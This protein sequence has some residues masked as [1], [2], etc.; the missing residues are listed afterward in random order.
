M[1]YRKSVNVKCVQNTQDNYKHMHT[2]HIVIINACEIH[3]K[4][5]STER[6]L[7]NMLKLK[8]YT[9]QIIILIFWTLHKMQKNKEY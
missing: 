7:H 2:H 1:L 8:E 5:N 6:Y 9:T 4:V 3:E